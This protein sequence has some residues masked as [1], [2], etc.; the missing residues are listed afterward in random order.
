MINV[1]L[2]GC[3]MSAEQDD[4]SGKNVYFWLAKAINSS[5]DMSETKDRVKDI[6]QPLLELIKKTNTPESINLLLE[7]LV[8]SAEKGRAKGQNACYLLAQ[9]VT[10]ASANN[11]PAEQVNAILKLLFMIL[12]K[13]YAS[14]Q[15]GVIAASLEKAGVSPFLRSYAEGYLVKQRTGESAEA[16]IRRFESYLNNNHPFYTMI[17]EPA[18]S[19]FRLLTSNKPS[20]TLEKI[21]A[22]VS[23]Y[24]NDLATKAETEAR[25]ISLNK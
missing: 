10:S 14:E 20:T 7:G 17:A 13:A 18:G 3:A 4:D 19:K 15:H 16:R 22:E 11:L 12:E 8:R 6:T 23:H 9:A 24:K 2:K 21:K 25:S 5:V 1:I